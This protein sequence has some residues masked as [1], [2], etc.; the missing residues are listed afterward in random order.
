VGTPIYWWG[1]TAQLKA[2]ID[3]WRLAGAGRF[4]P[5]KGQRVILSGKT[6]V[7]TGGTDGIGR[8]AV[9]MLYQMGASVVLLGRNEAKG[10]AVIRELVTAGATGVE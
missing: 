3:R 5:F 2:F 6:I 7:F 4:V 10:E 1:P 9:E 8:V